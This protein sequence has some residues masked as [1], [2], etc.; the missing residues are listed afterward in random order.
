V[1]CTG[2]VTTSK[3][4]SPYVTIIMPWNS[5]SKCKAL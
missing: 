1:M 5:T 3:T 2:I 4:Q